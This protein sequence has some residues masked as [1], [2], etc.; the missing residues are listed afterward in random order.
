MARWV[1]RN[2]CPVNDQVIEE[3]VWFGQTKLLGSRS[4]MERTAETIAG[5]TVAE[6]LRAARRQGPGQRQ[7]AHDMPPAHA[8][9]GVT[10]KQDTGRGHG[11]PDE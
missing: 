7:A 9:A 11:R 10:D 8:R 5:T 1:E 3:A 6:A 4:D 2:R